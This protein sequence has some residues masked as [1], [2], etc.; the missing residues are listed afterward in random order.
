M[1]EPC[2]TVVAVCRASTSYLCFVKQVVGG[3]DI[4]EPSDAVL[5]TASPAMTGWWACVLAT[6]ARVTERGKFSH[7]ST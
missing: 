2:R 3:W 5:R 7:K 4:G 1:H 6:C